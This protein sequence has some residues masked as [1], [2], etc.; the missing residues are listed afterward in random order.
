VSLRR[1]GERHGRGAVS[2]QRRMI[3]ERVSLRKNKTKQ[4]VMRLRKIRGITQPN[5]PDVF[6]LGVINCGLAN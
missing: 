6:R 1:D 2:A 5:R 3:A 4:S